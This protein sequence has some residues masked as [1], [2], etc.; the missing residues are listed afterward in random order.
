[1]VDLEYCPSSNN[2]LCLTNMTGLSNIIYTV[3]PYASSLYT[4]TAVALNNNKLYGQE[5]RLFSVAN[6]DNNYYIVLGKDTSDYIYFF[7]KE[8]GNFNNTNCYST[9]QFDIDMVNNVQPN[10]SVGYT[11]IY[12]GSSATGNINFNTITVPYNTVCQ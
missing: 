3:D 1:M 9:L 7:D 4:T 8:I 11:N 6:Y 10:M 2:V 12:Q 5:Q